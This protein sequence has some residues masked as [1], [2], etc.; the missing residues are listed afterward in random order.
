MTYYLRKL[1][2]RFSICFFYSTHYKAQIE[3]NDVTNQYWVDYNFTHPISDKIVL[4]GSTGARFVSP[5]IWSRYY[6]RHSISFTPS[7]TSIAGK[8]FIISLRTGISLFYTNNISSPNLIEISPFQGVDIKSSPNK[9]LQLGLYICLEERFEY[10]N[11]ANDF[12]MRARFRFSGILRPKN[13]SNQQAIFSDLYFPMHAEIFW[14][15]E[16]NSQFNDLIRITPGIGYFATL[17][18]KIEF[19]MSYFRSKNITTGDFE[20]NDLVFRLRLFHDF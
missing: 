5:H 8:E 2:F 4:Y 12:G 14:S 10:T 7:S 9:P 6:I 18:L 19:S 17:A 3:N 20:T 13:T 16:E 15:F 1:L 11:D